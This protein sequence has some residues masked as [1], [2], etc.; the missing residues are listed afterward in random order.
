VTPSAPHPNAAV[1]TD[2]GLPRPPPDRSSGSRITRA[3][4]TESVR[5]LPPPLPSAQRTR[6]RRCGCAADPRTPTGTSTFM[7][8][9]PPQRRGI[10][11]DGGLGSTFDRC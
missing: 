10:A 2:T 9:P 7:D 5:F 3:R 4:P 6:S 8:T 11:A 1:S